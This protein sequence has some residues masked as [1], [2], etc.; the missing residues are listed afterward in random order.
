[1]TWTLQNCRGHTTGDFCEVCEDGYQGDP[2][3]GECGVRETPS[4]CSCDA[5]GSVSPNCP[6]GRNCVCK[7]F[8]ELI[9]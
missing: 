7:V 6:D 5:R 1:M 4:V 8:I 3:T 9:E 2:R